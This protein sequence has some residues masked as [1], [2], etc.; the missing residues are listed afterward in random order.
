MAMG[1]FAVDDMGGLDVAW[2][3]RQE[4]NQFAEPG[5]PKPLVADALVRAGRLG[6]KTGKGW[7][8]YDGGRKADSGSRDDRPHRSGDGRRGHPPPRV[9]DDEIR[10]AD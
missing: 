7:Y 5:A 10:R 8:R 2:R 4:L 6:Q 1:I 3:V 9:S